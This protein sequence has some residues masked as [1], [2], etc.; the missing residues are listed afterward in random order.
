MALSTAGI[1]QR[2]KNK[3]KRSPHQPEKRDAFCTPEL[4]MFI[5][6]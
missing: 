3:D 5:I 1:S 4:L 2:R 6:R